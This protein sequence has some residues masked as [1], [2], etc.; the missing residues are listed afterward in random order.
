VLL[1]KFATQILCYSNLTC[2]TTVHLLHDCVTKAMSSC[3]AE[4]PP[5]PK[6]AVAHLA[7]AWKLPPTKQSNSPLP[8]S[9]SIWYCIT[10]LFPSPPRPAREEGDADTQISS[11]AQT[12]ALLTLVEGRSARLLHP[13]K[14]Q[15]QE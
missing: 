7:V 9:F 11:L 2:N 15:R 1:A 3:S 8:P 14:L 13:L 5:W 10:P 4:R 12:W 6:V